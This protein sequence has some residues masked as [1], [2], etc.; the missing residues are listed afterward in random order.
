[1]AKIETYVLATSPLSFSD[2]LIGTE[3]DGPI[4]NATK[5]FS[6]QEL[7]GLFA[8]IPIT[9]NLQQVLDTGNTATQDIVLTGDISST[10]ITPQY[11]IDM[12]SSDGIVGDVL[13]RAVGGMAWGSIAVPNLQQVLDQGSNAVGDAYLNGTFT[14]KT[15]YPGRIKDVSGSIGLTGQVLY[16]TGAGILWDNLPVFNYP[17]LQEVLNIG[18]VATAD[19]TL[20]GTI[21]TT[22]VKPT[23]IIDDLSATGAVGEVLT[24]SSTGIRWL[25]P[26]ASGVNAV[27]ATAPITSSGGANPDISSSMNTNKLIGRST[28]G[29]GVMEEI[30]IGSGLSLSGG[31]L[32]SSGGGG[33]GLKSGIATGTDTYAVTISGVT[34]YTDGDAYLVRF[35]NGNTTGCTLNINTLGAKDL[36]RNNDGALIGGDIQNN[37]EMICVYNSTLNAFQV[38]GTSPNSLI[39]Y[40]TN[41]DSVTITKGMPV[42]A[43]SGTGDRM[44]VKRAYNTGDSTS[45][46]TVGLVLSSSIA[47]NQKGFIMMQGLLD[48]LSVLPTSTWAD[49]DPVYL[50]ATAGTLTNVKPYA[51]NHLVYL[52]FVTTA[53]NGSAGRLY[54]R[55]QNGYELDE[56]HNVQART[57]TYKDTLWYDNTVSPA[58]W[59]TASIATILGYTPQAALGGTGL[60]KSTAGTITYITDN[61]TNW[62]TAYSDR[63]KWDGG[64]TGLTASTGRTSLGADTVGSNLFTLANPSAITFIRINADNSI[65]ALDAATFRTAISAQQSLTNP[66]TGTGTNNEI[67]YFNSTGS[68]IASLSVATYP[69]LTELSYV[70]GVT[71]AI[72]TQINNKGYSINF[73]AAQATIAAST[74]YYFGLVGGG[75]ATASAQRRV[76]IP[77]A[78]TVKEIYIY[79]RTTNG[80]LGETWT[81]TF[82]LN[83]TSNTT[84]GSTATT[85]QDKVYSNSNLNVSVVAGDY[86]EITTTTPA[87]APGVSNIYGTLVIH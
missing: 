85:S 51:P 46:Q 50:G 11:I 26:T 54:V 64:A 70:K 29:V 52:G 22:N 43:F 5:N 31:V 59:K 66:V 78:G 28:A 65:S 87:T 74:T 48:G 61:S 63:M 69:S 18:W 44:T 3:I 23:Y 75:V 8:T 14:T 72:Q 77:L 76:Y 37:G 24:R 82:R 20:N 45:A 55:V 81:M 56:L 1:M 47:P 53:S 6:L 7:Y 80:T 67:S 13:M 62:D 33:G 42:Y 40:V 10:T 58:Q 36:Y 27:T 19:M 35:T 2:M 79:V 21:T 60:V 30:T 86:F 34:S 16:K 41:D 71:S 25:A 15:I 17:G 57:P 49:G 73:G 4:P 38:I 84:I 9:G 32:T 12:L 39:A 68:T 83:N